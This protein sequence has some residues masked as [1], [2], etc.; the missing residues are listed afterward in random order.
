MLEPLADRVNLQLIDIEIPN[1]SRSV[2]I[3]FR[4]R[5]GANCKK[6]SCRVKSIE[7][8]NTVSKGGSGPPS[9]YPVFKR[10]NFT[11]TV[12]ISEG[13]S[14]FTVE[15]SDKSPNSASTVVYTNNGHG[16]PYD[17]TILVQR[18]LS[19]FNP[20]PDGF[21]NLTVAVSIIHISNFVHTFTNV[22]SGS[23]QLQNH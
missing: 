20:S 13:I 22:L 11:M 10:W 9:E 14:S 6:S 12:P 21:L 16:Y 19:C 1:P 23:R 8:P 5:A 17:D 18:N 3:T 7:D 2:E 15:V 4:N